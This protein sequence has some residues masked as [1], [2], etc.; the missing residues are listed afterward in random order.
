MNKKDWRK[1]TE[2]AEARLRDLDSKATVLMHKFGALPDT[3]AVAEFFM[4][5]V[6]EA[7]EGLQSLK[8]TRLGL[9]ELPVGENTT[10]VLMT[11]VKS[12]ANLP[13][14]KCGYLLTNDSVCTKCGAPQQADRAEPVF[15]ANVRDPSLCADCLRFLV[16]GTCPACSKGGSQPA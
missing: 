11:V 16:D 10:P 1:R 9:V 8:P 13:C 4:A 7:L 3:V 12:A 5:F 15:V 6:E 2:D 14:A